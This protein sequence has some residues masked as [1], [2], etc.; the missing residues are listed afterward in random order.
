MTFLLDHDVPLEIGR[1]IRR[2]G[3]PAQRVV[4]CLS[5]TATDAEVLAHA[6]SQG[7]ILVTCNRGDFLPLAKEIAPGGLVILIRRKT[8]QAECAKLLRLLRQA[9][10]AGLRGNVNFA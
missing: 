6:K 9:G 5:A 7:W 2:E 1:L 3:Y 4:E 10:E 8:R